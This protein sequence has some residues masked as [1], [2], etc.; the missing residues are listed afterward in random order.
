MGGGRDRGALSF[1]LLFNGERAGGAAGGDEM[2]Y[3]W[4]TLYAAY[5]LGRLGTALQLVFMA[6]AYTATLRGHRSRSDRAR[7]AG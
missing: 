5:Y 1:G 3:L 6:A 7:A 4:V 2:F